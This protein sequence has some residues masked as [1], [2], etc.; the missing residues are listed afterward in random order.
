M[1]VYHSLPWAGGANGRSE[2]DRSDR[3]SLLLAP[4]GPRYSGIHTEVSSRSAAQD[5][6]RRGA[7]SRS[8]LSFDW[9]FTY[10]ALRMF[11]RFYGS[12]IDGSRPALLIH[13][14]Q[15]PFFS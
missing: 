13:L 4:H 11:Q 10:H 1:E 9:Q 14:C 3:P 8:S 2:D 5:T 7:G 15:L 12:Q 6:S